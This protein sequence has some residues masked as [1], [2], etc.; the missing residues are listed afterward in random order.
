MSFAA[1]AKA[2]PAGIPVTIS[3]SRRTKLLI[4]ACLLLL[5]QVV[6][7]LHTRWVEDE[8]WYSAPADSLARHGE[9]KMRVFA[10]PGQQALYDPRPPLPMLTMAGL[11]HLFGTNLY[12]ARIPFILAAIGGLFVTYLLGCE[13]RSRALGLTAAVFLAAD[14]LYFLAARTVRPESMVAALSTAGVLLF[15]QAQRKKSVGLALLAGM[16]VGVGALCHPTALGGGIIAGVFALREFG[17]S[18]VRRARPWAFAAGLLLAI[19]PYIAVGVSNPVRKDEFV[20]LYVNGQGQPLS[21]IPELEL[22]RYSDFLGMPSGRFKAPIPVPYRLQIVLALLAAFYILYRHDRDLFTKLA[23]PI[24][25]FMVWWAFLRFQTVRYM[26]TASPYFALLLGGATLTLWNWRPQWRRLAAAAA[27]L[28]IVSGLGTNYGLLFLYRKADYVGLG[29]QLEAVI[30]PG[31]PVYGALTF[32]M[33]LNDHEY[34]SWNRAPLRYAVE[35]GAQYLILNDRVLLNGSGFGKD[36][37]VHVRDRAAAFV[38]ENAT[39]VARVPNPFYGDLEVYR[40][41]PTAVGAARPR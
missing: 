20:R 29:K 2:S 25:C 13:L 12:I 38:R 39:L 18:I 28:V 5:A 15:L 31:A 3:D 33:A 17:F 40:V 16:A 1:T 34:F 11:F 9:L 7:L 37:W 19:A 41:N 23:I 14:T 22:S 32:W 21:A 26:A 36:D 35:H 24:A 4:F 27:L 30:P 6:P 8:S 10:P